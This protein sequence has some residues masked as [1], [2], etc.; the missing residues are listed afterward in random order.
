M[1][2]TDK[3]L[4]PVQEMTPEQV[5]LIKRTICKGATDDELQLFLYQCRRTGLDP[6]ARQAYAI[7]RWDKDEKRHVMTIQT[8]IDGFRLIAERTGK[9]AGQTGP[10]WCGRDGEWRD[11]WLDEGPPL[12]AKVGVLRSDF[13]EPLWAV[14]RYATHVQRTKEG[15]ANR[16]WSTMPD[17]MLAK[18]A[19]AMALRRAFP[20]ELSGLYSD[21][22]MAQADPA[23]APTPKPASRDR[24]AEGEY[25]RARKDLIDRLGDLLQFRTDDGVP[26]FRDEERAL[27]KRQI[28]ETK[29]KPLSHLEDL[30]TRWLDEQGLRMEA[31]VAD[32]AEPAPPTPEQERE[33][34]DVFGDPQQ[35]I[36][37]LEEAARK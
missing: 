26:L 28:E 36:A 16:F 7:K 14:A 13:A 6:L 29:G 15:K 33:L 4:V 1:S 32:A 30:F 31:A 18:C 37:D 27:V 25:L 3:A 12:A 21:D 9:Y 8:G 17:V 35:Q 11:V 5:D 34:E 23:S 10:L 2:A 24:Q 20:Q 22:E 19:E